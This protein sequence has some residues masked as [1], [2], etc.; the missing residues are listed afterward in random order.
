MARGARGASLRAMVIGIGVDLFEV[1]RMTREL[2]GRDPGLR[3][4][5][6]TP[7]EIACCEATR[8]PMLHY[9]ARFAAKEAVFKALSLPAGAGA[10]WRDIEIRIRG[11]TRDVSLH[12]VMKARG[13]ALGVRGVRL[14]LSHR[15]GL[16]MASVVLGG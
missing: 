16:A 1:A 8:R 2:R 11:R 3:E 4:E 7:A 10:S 15:R 12:G 5:L 9:A 6:F 13:E 14:S